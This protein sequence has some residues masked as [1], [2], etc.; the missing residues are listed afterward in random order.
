MTTAP[1]VDSPQR[2]PTTAP[3]EQLIQCLQGLQPVAI[4]VSGGVDSLTLATLA[5]R[6]LPPGA[7]LVFHAVSPAVPEHATERV[8]ALAKQEGWRLTIFDAGEFGN[9]DYRSNPVN[10][11]F[12]C[13]YSLYEGIRQLT[14]ATLL[15]GT[16][17]DD[18]GE[19]RPGLDAARLFNVRHPYVEVDF[20][21]VAVRRLAARLGLGDVAELPAA[22]CLAS[23]VETGLRIEAATLRLVYQVE[24]L[25]AASLKPKVVRCRIRHGAI[26]IELDP[27]TLM[28]LADQSKLQL[29]Q[30]ISALAD[31]GV[32]VPAGTNVRYEPYRVGSAFL[33]P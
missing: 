25:V 11:C 33:H 2:V 13:K 9:E 7:C 1:E 19:Y 29:T 21:K 27:Q 16:N 17:R 5:H 6:V 3:E 28:R 26:V 10:R 24:Q 32:A 23:R 20:T 30:A 4:A 14:G 22:P 15:S 31:A 8:R 12:H 18:L